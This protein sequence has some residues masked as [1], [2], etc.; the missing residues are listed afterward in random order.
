MLPRDVNV[1]PRCWRS[2][3]RSAEL[4]VYDRSLHHTDSFRHLGLSQLRRVS[5][6]LKDVH[7]IG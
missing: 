6:L 2:W 3:G 4:V 7:G 5:Y 1:L